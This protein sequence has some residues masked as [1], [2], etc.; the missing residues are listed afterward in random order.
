METQIF[1]TKNGLVVQERH[2]YGGSLGD[3]YVDVEYSI[4]GTNM[5]VSYTH[6]GPE[7]RNYPVGTVVY[8]SEDGTKPSGWATD[9]EDNPRASDLKKVLDGTHIWVPNTGLEA[10]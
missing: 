10:I 2:V 3:G 8:A 1:P 5:E 7:A 6:V 4:N 9:N